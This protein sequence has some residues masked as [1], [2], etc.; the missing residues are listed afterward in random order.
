MP[1]NSLNASNPFCSGFLGLPVVPRLNLDL[2]WNIFDPN[3]V[4]LKMF[5]ITWI[6][7]SIVNLWRQLTWLWTYLVSWIADKVMFVMF[8]PG[9]WRLLLHLTQFS[10]NCCKAFTSFASVH[11][12][13]IL[14]VDVFFLFVFL[15][16]GGGRA[17][18]AARWAPVEASLFLGVPTCSRDGHKE[19]TGWRRPLVPLLEF[20]HSTQHTVPQRGWENK[21]KTIRSILMGMVYYVK[22]TKCFHI[23]VVACK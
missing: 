19:E 3:V 14:Y 7:V 2:D 18:E 8:F 13:T 9:V 20:K 23:V 6:I 11:K 12:F 4:D 10:L 22:I 1:H 15:N 21:T 17:S 16:R 5:F